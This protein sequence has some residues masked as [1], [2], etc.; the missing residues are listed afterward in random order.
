MKVVEEML[1][2]ALEADQSK[3]PMERFGARVVR[4]V[5]APLTEFF[6]SELERDKTKE[7]VERVI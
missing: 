2:L 7:E 1:T 5:L 6:L 4:A 3:D